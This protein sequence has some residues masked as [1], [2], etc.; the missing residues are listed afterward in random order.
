MTFLP[1]PLLISLV[2]GL[3]SVA[4]LAAGVALV[5]SAVRRSRRRRPVVGETVV[6]QRR[7]R[8]EVVQPVAS[9]RVET[10]F[11]HNP[12][13][14][15][16]LLPGLVLLLVAIF[17]RHV[18]QLGFA[19]GQDEPQRAR[20][21]AMKKLTRPDGTIIRA[22]VYGPINAPTLVLTH[23][24]G[25]SSSEWYYAKRQ[26]SDRFRLIVWDLPALGLSE[27]PKDQD[28]ALEK[29]TADL[30]TVLQLADGKRVVLVGHSIGGMINLTFCRL[31]PELLGSSV[32]GIV[33]VD[34]T[35][36][37]QSRSSSLSLYS[38]P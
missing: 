26:L 15:K 23:G 3:I 34:T 28:F 13:L 17:G 14:W 7:E 20:S 8:P 35:S 21:G 18:A 25:T 1:I 36:R 12:G 4:I 22:E 29:M 37:S 31:Y 30:R 6:D 2:L 24:W 38:T 16:M 32:A 10:D 33:Q 5:A 11:S 9:G 19:H 27:Q